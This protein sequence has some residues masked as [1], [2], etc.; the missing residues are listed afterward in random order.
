[1]IVCLDADCTIYFVEQNP[2]WGPKVTARLAAL[3]A[4]G[5]EIAVSD[6]AR[7]ECL[8]QPLAVGD[9]AVVADYQAFFT[10]P[11]IRVLALTA[12]VCERAAR[13]RAA[14]WFKL[15]VPD[16]LHLAAAVEHGCGLFLT[17]DAQLTRC[18][19]ITVEILS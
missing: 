5:D 6:L 3:R 13:I 14:S 4:G 2:V 9:T 12:A 18:K 1:M 17:H 10:D 19:D 11:G 16:C 8:A 7:T 15:K